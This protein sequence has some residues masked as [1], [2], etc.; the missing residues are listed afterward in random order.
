MMKKKGI[1]QSV[2]GGERIHLQTYLEQLKTEHSP[3]C[4]FF[5]L[6]PCDPLLQKDVGKDNP[7]SLYLRTR[8]VGH[9]CL[10]GGMCV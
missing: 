3:S 7:V 9:L 2:R 5:L 1:S 6:A 8:V 4:F 10:G